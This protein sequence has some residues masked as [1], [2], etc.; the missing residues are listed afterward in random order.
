M[1]ARS[2]LLVAA[3]VGPAPLLAH[4]VVYPKTS[5]PGAYE[6]YVL[7]VPNEKGSATT[8]IEIRFPADAKVISFADVP[9]WTVQPV[10]DSAQRIV[11]AVWTGT[12]AP[13]RFVEL[14]FIAVN[15]KGAARLVWPV[16]QS[17]AD[18]E[19]VEWTG[20]EDAKAPAS[21]TDIAESGPRPLA[22]RGPL[23]MGLLSLALSLIA[24]G[25]ALRREGPRAARA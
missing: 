1:L 13:Q 15:P 21:A 24:L 6:R 16:F 23:V 22:G 17:Y 20:A 10:L 11:G 5:T 2:L 4:A 9:G 3:L 14:P 7:R 18:G 19:R 25:L 8:R 12:L